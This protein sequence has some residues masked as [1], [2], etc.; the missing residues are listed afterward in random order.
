MRNIYD[1]L[2]L[3]KDGL[4]RKASAA[5][6]SKGLAHLNKPPVKAALKEKYPRPTSACPDVAGLAPGC[7]DADVRPFN[8]E[9]VLKYLNSRGRKCAAGP[10]GFSYDNM[11]TL[12]NE[13]NK[14]G[15]KDPTI[16]ACIS[17]LISLIA[18]GRFNSDKRTARILASAH[19]V[20]L[21]KSS[22]AASTAV[23]PIA[24][25]IALVRAAGGLLVKRHHDE[26]RALE[27]PRQLGAERGG[28]EIVYLFTSAAL[29]ENPE[30]VLASLDAKNAFNSISK[31][32]LLLAAARVPG[33]LPF[34]D[35]TF[36]KAH[37]VTYSH[38]GNKINNLRI[39]AEQGAPQGLPTV[40]R[41]FCAA[42]SP[43]ADWV[44]ATYGND[45]VQHVSFAD[46]IY[47]VGPP[48]D[49]LKVSLEYRGKLKED[50]ELDI[51]KAELY[52]P[53]GRLSE[54]ERV[55]A[56]EMGFT[57]EDE[58]ILV[59]GVPLG[60]PAFVKANAQR[61]IEAATRGAATDTM[62]LYDASSNGASLQNIFNHFR[63]QV[64]ARVNHIL[65]SIH[66][67]SLDD[68]FLERMDAI[69]AA[70]VIDIVGAKPAFDK[71][72]NSD[73]ER[74]TTI[75]QG[76]RTAANSG[77]MD[78][79]SAVTTGLAAWMGSFAASA[80]PVSKLLK[81]DAVAKGAP[82]PQ[83]M[84]D[85]AAS[86]EQLR[87]THGHIEKL[88]TLLDQ[89]EPYDIAARRAPGLQHSFADIV[90]ESWGKYREREIL[91]RPVTTL[92]DRARRDQVVAAGDSKN[93][94]AF[95][96][97]WVRAPAHWKGCGMSDLAYAAAT[98][99][100][101]GL[102]AE[103]VPDSP[104]CVCGKPA[105]AMGTHAH[106]CPKL[107]GARSSRHRGILHA[108][109]QIARGA[110]LPV[111]HEPF[112]ASYY[113]QPDPETLDATQQARLATP[114]TRA[115]AAITLPNN[116]DGRP[117]LVDVVVIGS[118]SGAAGAKPI[119]RN[120]VQQRLKSAEEA[121]T[122]HYMDSW[123]IANPL[124]ALVPFALDVAGNPGK[125]AK[126]FITTMLQDSA[127]GNEGA[128]EFS[129]V[130]AGRKRHA[131]TMIAVAL[132]TMNFATLG[133]WKVS[134]M[135][136]AAPVGAATAAPPAATDAVGGRGGRGGRGGNGGTV[137]RGGRGGRGRRVP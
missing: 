133:R 73:P 103:G 43:T 35:L 110:G 71:I 14:R 84:A 2:G 1:A 117:V 55:S 136:A 100:R 38:R 52:A 115:D 130:A 12:I 89:C 125:L 107:Q 11:K 122:K 66:P 10:G 34:A 67:H 47:F 131:W 74:A 95:A 22:E 132:Q 23:R 118:T 16:L 102:P 19:G 51:G 80:A 61:L 109:E 29:K 72:A 93:G 86:H 126:D 78:F 81:L 121:K 99:T 92:D 37:D 127:V 4:H 128:D 6:S 36:G 45:I 123:V 108:V 17:L 68:G 70:T 119:S 49:V 114:K 129:G 69:V 98:R 20:A 39:V 116:I 41:C 83:W 63:F 3:L 105:D 26:L 31:E 59:M 113:K 40:P 44:V 90:A 101:L 7:V 124:K 82:A 56:L 96:G 24:I 97:A 28:A 25:G 85:Y 88:A 87:K 33:M 27:G 5:L 9:D 8:D 13:G 46:N 106:V 30:W 32:K 58:G 91:E 79:H 18:A 60:S 48:S 53:E 112:L 15:T 54:E 21:A 135:G 134:C 104:T 65:R 42:T 111:Q 75:E 62:E 64:P 57:V 77:G 137:M 120:D 50:L 76:V 94:G